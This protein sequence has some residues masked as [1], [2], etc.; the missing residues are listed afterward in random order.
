MKLAN[1]L[2]L[3]LPV[4]YTMP[5]SSGNSAQIR[6][7]TT[8]DELRQS[9]AL[10]LEALKKGEGIAVRDS[11]TNIHKRQ[12]LPGVAGMIFIAIAQIT[13]DLGNAAA[14]LSKIFGEG[15]DQIW[16]DTGY[17]RT[18]FSTHGGGECKT[19]TYKKGSL[20][21]TAE[22]DSPE[23]AWIDPANNDPPVVFYEGDD[24]IGKYSVQYTATDSFAWDGIEGTVKCFFQGIC[25]PQYVFY[26][27]GYNIVL[28]TWQSEGDPTS[29]QLEDCKGLCYTGIQ[30][31]FR[32]NGNQWGGDC[33]IP[34]EDEGKLPE[35]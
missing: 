13:G 31:Q 4:A 34:C 33:A 10:T 22:H 29:C 17:C 24:G 7:K 19:R 28:N 6:D 5:T 18:Y 11:I 26:R 3:G 2:A 27:D 20:D 21:A 32:S 30:N 35:T 23:C 25:Y 12:A 15:Q 9:H 16:H 8:L 1:V 14:Q